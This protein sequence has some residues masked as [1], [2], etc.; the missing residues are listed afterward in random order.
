MRVLITGG[1]GSFGG[2]RPRPAGQK[3]GGVSVFPRRPDSPQARGLATQGA[4]LLLGD[5]TVRETVKAAL[6]VARPEVFFHNAG[7]YE[8]GIPRRAQ[9]QMRAVNVEGTEHALALAAEAGVR[10]TV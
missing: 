9:R 1:P 5:V 10:R 3:A 7:W 2:R 4:R 8:L 6:E